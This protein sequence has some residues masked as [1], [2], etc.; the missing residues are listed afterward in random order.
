MKGSEA[1]VES[2]K[3]EGVEAIFG[4]PGGVVIPLYD[5]LYDADIKHYLVRHEQGAAHMADGYARATGKTGVCIAT[6]GPGATN[7]VTGIATAYMDSTPMVAI[8]GQVRSGL[9]GT[10]AFQE[11]DTTG[12]TQ[13]IVKHSYLIKDVK[14]IPRIFKE[15]FYIASSGR[16][17]PVVIDIP[18]DMQLAE[19]DYKPQKK[20]NL[21]GYKP[22]LK[23]NRRQIKAAAR[24]I[25]RAERPVI[26][27]GGGIISSGA[28]RE[29][30]RL[31]KMVQTPVT[32]TL[33]GL[34]TFPE[35]DKL[36]LGMLGMHGTG[37]ANYAVTNCD[38]LIAIGARFDDRVTGKLATFA[39]EAKKIH[40]DQDPAE[41]SKNVVVDVPIV[42]DARTVLK[43]LL[44][45]LK[46]LEI[47]T[48]RTE[49]WLRQV[50]DWKKSH[51]LFYKDLK[52]EI[53]PQF[54]VE[55][56]YR[57]TKGKAIICTEVGQNQMWAALFY[58]H[59]KARNFISSGG[60]GT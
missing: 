2:L 27:A 31:A 57:V 9:I 18:V 17:G 38:L 49:P 44:E 45:E 23:G 35:T 37:Y 13:P 34:G 51:P 19:L 39:A 43:D 6:S 60:L 41:I 53:M 30:R 1:I 36:S 58:Q 47:D 10:D 5:T 33:M 24:L 26:Y 8:T 40:I 56:I 50:S 14:D 54:V 16:P 32:T 46:K 29:L 28:D 42:G 15:A 52:R 48:G 59:S 12:I 55:E 3:A 25:A 20:I 11:A 22:T 4:L 21:L 7:L